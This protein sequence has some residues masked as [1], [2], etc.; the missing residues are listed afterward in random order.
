MK[1]P[2]NAAQSVRFP[3]RARDWLAVELLEEPDRWRRVPESRFPAGLTGKRKQE[4][5]LTAPEKK[6]L[7]AFL[8]CL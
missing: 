1:I 5:I 7:V 3:G 8:R 2:F 4:K 6:D